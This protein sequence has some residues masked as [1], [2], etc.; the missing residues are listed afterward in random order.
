MQKRITV[1]IAHFPDMQ[2]VGDHAVDAVVVIFDLRDDITGTCAGFVIVEIGVAFGLFEL[3][4][5]KTVEGQIAVL[6]E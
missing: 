4:H 5:G 2:V 1:Q 6:V 3:I